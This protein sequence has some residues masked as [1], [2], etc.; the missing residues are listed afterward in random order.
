MA[1]FKQEEKKEISSVC[2]SGYVSCERILISNA[3]MTVVEL[4]YKPFHCIRRLYFNALPECAGCRKDM[5]PNCFRLKKCY[6]TP[7]LLELL[8]RVY[9]D[10]ARINR[11]CNVIWWDSRWYGDIVRE[12]KS[13]SAPSVVHNKGDIVEKEEFDV[14]F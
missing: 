3:N 8:I 10:N 4:G 9:T 2:H 12:I 13:P 6:N 11:G 14:P 5:F 1:L 7:K